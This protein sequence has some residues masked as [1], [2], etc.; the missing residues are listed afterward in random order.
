MLKNTSKLYKTSL[1]CGRI[2]IYHGFYRAKHQT[3]LEVL[4]PHFLYAHAVKMVVF[5]NES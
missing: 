2:N 4:N 1:S 3:K 5:G